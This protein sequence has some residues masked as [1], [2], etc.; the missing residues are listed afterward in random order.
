MSTTYS[1]TAAEARAARTLSPLV[2][3]LAIVDVLA[4]GWAVAAAAGAL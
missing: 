2:T 1:R 4:I 3:V